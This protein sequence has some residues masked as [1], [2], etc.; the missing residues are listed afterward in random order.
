MKKYELTNKKIKVDGHTLYR[1]RALTNFRNGKAGDCGGYIEHEYNLYHAG[2]CWIYGDAYVYA[3]AQVCDDAQVMGDA[4][5]HG[6]ARVYGNARVYKHACVYGNAEVCGNAQVCGNSEVYG[7]SLV[8]GNK[9]VSGND[10]VCG[11][12]T[13]YED[14]PVDEHALVYETDSGDKYARVS[15]S[16]SIGVTT[17]LNRHQS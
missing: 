7:K 12:V 10:W 16:D 6:D 4:R 13:I 3:N 1:I 9:Y 8:T 11:N 14:G 15:I 2:S 17:V 5:V